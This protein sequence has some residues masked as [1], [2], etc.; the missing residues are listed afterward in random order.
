MTARKATKKTAKRG[1]SQKQKARKTAS[2]AK[3]KK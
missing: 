3:P 2:A 1:T